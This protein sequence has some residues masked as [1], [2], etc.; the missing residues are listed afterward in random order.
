MGG[1]VGPS[2]WVLEWVGGSV[3][4][5]GY[6]SGRVDPCLWVLQWLG[7]SMLVGTLVGGW[8]RAYGHLSGW[9]GH[10]GWYISGRMNLCL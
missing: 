1:W 6:S 8:A 4:V 5:C 3:H 10:V 9:M 2:L 7:G